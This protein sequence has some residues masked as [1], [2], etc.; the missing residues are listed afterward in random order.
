MT[1]PRN[2]H[3]GVKSSGNAVD[4]K[5]AHSGAPSLPL[6]V[7]MSKSTSTFTR[8]NETLEFTSCRLV[9]LVVQLAA[10]TAPTP[11][12]LSPDTRKVRQVTLLRQR[13]SLGAVKPTRFSAV[14]KHLQP[15]TE[16]SLAAAQRNA[17][18]CKSTRY[19]LM[20]YKRRLFFFFLNAFLF[21]TLKSLH[22]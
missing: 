6:C 16:Y 11:P 17:V 19:P 13:L 3:C 1:K 12:S 20:L 14:C 5:H 21:P 15:S 4:D 22:L 9:F 18:T 8:D 7:L 10:S 2:L